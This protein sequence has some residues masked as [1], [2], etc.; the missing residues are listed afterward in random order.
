MNL[1]ES[2]RKILREDF[3]KKQ[4]S[5]SDILTNLKNQ[6][7]EERREYQK[8]TQTK[9]NGDYERAAKEYAKLKN[10][11]FDDI[12]GDKERMEKFIPIYFDFDSFSDDDWENYWL[13]SQHAD[14]YPN[15]QK[16]A[17]ETISQYL[18]KDNDN[19]RYLHDRISCRQTGT[20]KYGTQ[21]ICEKY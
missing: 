8:F 4:N 10:R 13:I 21:N 9:F 2:I 19:Y 12:F 1:Q 15:F 7:Q 6:D 17:L 14:M 3:D 16:D 20:Q 11:R 5:Q 18:G